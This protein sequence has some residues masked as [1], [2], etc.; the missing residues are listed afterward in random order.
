MYYQEVGKKN[1]RMSE[2]HEEEMD[3]GCD[4]GSYTIEEGAETESEVI[5]GID[6]E[7]SLR[8][9]MYWNLNSEIKRST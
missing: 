1:F 9:A 7:P 4:I 5:Q 2:N 6:A 8:W 3:F